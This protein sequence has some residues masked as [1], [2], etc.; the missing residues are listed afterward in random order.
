MNNERIISALD[1]ALDDIRRVPANTPKPPT[2]Q[3]KKV[4]SDNTLW[5][6]TTATDAIQC[7]I[8][9]SSFMRMTASNADNN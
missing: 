3:E 7:I 9:I 8:I 6:A 2:P 5:F 1:D 4:T